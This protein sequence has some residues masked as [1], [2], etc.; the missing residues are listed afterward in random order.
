MENLHLY[1]RFKILVNWISLLASITS[2]W[3]LK[4]GNKNLHSD[5]Y[6]LIFFNLF[7][8]VEALNYG[9]YFLQRGEQSWLD[10]ESVILDLLQKKASAKR[11][12]CQLNG[13]PQITPE[14]LLL[15]FPISKYFHSL[16]KIFHFLLL[17]CIKSIQ[18]KIQSTWMIKF[19]FKVKKR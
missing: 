4:Q 6:S 13:M 1:Q 15:L 2:T 9:K 18:F 12:H 11:F 8:L 3:V 19:I 5:V 10:Y 7:F 14:R 17:P 16:S